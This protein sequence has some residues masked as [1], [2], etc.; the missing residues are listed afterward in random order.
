MRKLRYLLHIYY[1]YFEYNVIII[2]HWFYDP[3]RFSINIVYTHDTS[4]MRV[5]GCLSDS[6][7]RRIFLL[8]VI[9]L[10]RDVTKSMT[11][12]DIPVGLV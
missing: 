7:A 6:W 10:K 12:S 1:M 11:C 8:M 3:I 4:S 5:S 2:I 9:P